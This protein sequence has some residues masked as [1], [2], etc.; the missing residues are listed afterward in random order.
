MKNIENIKKKWK[1]KLLQLMKLFDKI[2][3]DELI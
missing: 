1:K 2:L 3:F